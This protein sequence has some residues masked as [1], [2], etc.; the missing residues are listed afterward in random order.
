MVQDHEIPK[1]ARLY[2][3]QTAKIKRDIEKIAS[4]ILYAEGFEEIATPLFSYHQHKFIEDEKALIRLSDDKN[5]ELSLRADST[6][7]VVRLITNRL[8]RSTEHKKWFY[9]QPVYRYPTEEFHQIGAEVLESKDVAAILKILIKF[10][11][12]L[13]ITP[14]LQISNIK[15]PEILAQ[16]YGLGYEELKN[17]DI[18]TILQTQHPWIEKLLYL[19]SVEEIDECIAEVP[20][21]IEQELLKMKEL[22]LSIQYDKLLLA[23]LYYAKMRYYKDLFFRFF[24]KNSTL[25]MGGEYE[26]AGVEANGFSLYTDYLIHVVKGE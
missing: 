16:N 6:I 21:E 20:E 18:H 25:A 22:A 1:G 15:I 14:N 8:G 26:A 13:Q 17:G 3:G 19:Q 24:E 12:K 4:E 9:I 11:D 23:P 2:F 10:F 7:D 5:R